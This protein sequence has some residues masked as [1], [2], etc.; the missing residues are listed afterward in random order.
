MEWI[1]WSISGVSLLFV[2]LTFVRTWNK[3]GKQE[4]A[5]ENAKFESIKEGVLKANMKLDQVCASTTEM[6]SDL[7]SMNHELKAYSERLI[8]VERDLKTAF[9]LIDTIREQLKGGEKV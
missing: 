6:R 4:D 9:N 2:I 8:V 3:D 7:K 1:P 5:E